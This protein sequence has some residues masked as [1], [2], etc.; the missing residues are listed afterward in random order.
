MAKAKNEVM[1]LAHSG[2]SGAKNESVALGHSV[3][4]TSVDATNVWPHSTF[5]HW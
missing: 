4:T 3:R 1:T 5:V 2:A